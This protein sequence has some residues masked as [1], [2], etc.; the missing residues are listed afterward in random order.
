VAILDIHPSAL[1]ELEQ[2]AR[3]YEQQAT[4]LGHD[5]Q[6]EVAAC[7]DRIRRFPKAARLVSEAVRSVRVQRF[8]FNLIYRLDGDR[9]LVLA[10]M[11]Y[12]RRPDYWKN[13]L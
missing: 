10:A 5:F 11:H 6:K 7:L 13:R 3:F 1:M 12:R 9:I 8:P 2:S 4:G